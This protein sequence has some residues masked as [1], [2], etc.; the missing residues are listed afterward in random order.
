MKKKAQA[1]IRDSATG[2]LFLL[3]FILYPGLTNMIFAG[4]SCR[5]IGP[6]QSV[7]IV[8]YNVDCNSGDY[9]ALLLSCCALV[10]VWPLGLPATLF[11]SMWRE[12]KLIQEGDRDTLQ[13][14]DFA[15]G[16]YK[17]THWYWEVVSLLSLITLS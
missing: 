14:F 8:D 12:R 16:D 13:K 17:L 15:L 7:L 9:T 3:V 1:N 11:F 10:I 5:E 4:F 6:G 2:R